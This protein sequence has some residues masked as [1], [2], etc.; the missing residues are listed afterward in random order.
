MSD[1]YLVRRDD[2]SDRVAALATEVTANAD[3]PYDKALAIESYLRGFTYN[4]QIRRA[5]ARG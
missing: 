5:A 4:D 1:L 2:L 3:T